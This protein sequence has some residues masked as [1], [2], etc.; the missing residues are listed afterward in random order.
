MATL[1]NSLLRKLHDL[2]VGEP[3]ESPP[4]RPC[5]A[6]TDCRASI[7]NPYSSHTVQAIHVIQSV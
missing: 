7:Q 2:E 3:T 4:A 5:G 1:R 6:M